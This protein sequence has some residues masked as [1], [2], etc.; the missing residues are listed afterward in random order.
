MEIKFNL[1]LPRDE[2]SIPIV[3]RICTKSLTVLGVARECIGDVELALAEACA[4]VLLHARDN[5]EY[6]VSVDLDD[7]VAVIEVIDR[8]GGFDVTTADTNGVDGTAEHG[9][10]I[11]LMRALM[12]QVQFHPLGGPHPGTRVHLEKRLAWDEHAP[13]RRLGVEALHCGPWTDD[14]PLLGATQAGLC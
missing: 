4:N 9:R 6:D 11:V 12:D 1:S 7:Q 8:G 2:I 10:G 13:G 5:D 14:H 3:R